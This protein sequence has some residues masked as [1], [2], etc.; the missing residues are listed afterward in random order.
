MP[1]P[2]S[3]RSTVRAVSPSTQATAA[4]AI[5]NRRR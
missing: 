2:A 5:E 3:S 1:R 4:V